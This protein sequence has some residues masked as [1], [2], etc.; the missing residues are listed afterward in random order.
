MH[1]ATYIAMHPIIQHQCHLPDQ[2]IPY[3]S[4]YMRNQGSI[5]TCLLQLHVTTPECVIFW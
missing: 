1:A 4:I 5:N 3:D 2:D